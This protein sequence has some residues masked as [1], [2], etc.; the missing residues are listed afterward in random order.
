MDII[1]SINKPKGITSH[2]AV[3]KVKRNL[4][5]KKAGHTG[6]LDP[7]ATGLLLVCVN[8]ATRIASY[9]SNLDKEYRAVMK[10]GEATDT[11]D[12]EGQVIS[13]CD[14][15]DVD[16]ADIREALES[17]EGNILQQPPMFSALKHKGKP[18]YKLARKG[19][20]I[21]RKP[22]EVHIKYI[23]LLDINLPYVT[24]K[25]LCSKGTYIRT[26]CDDIGRKLGTGAHLYE[27]E[28]SGIGQYGIDESLSFNELESIIQGEPINKGIYTMDEALSWLPEFKI[29]DILLKQVVHGNPIKLNNR[30]DFSD[31]LKSAA[32]IRIKSHDGALLAIGSFSAVKN[33]IKMDIVFS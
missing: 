10:L 6:T 5:V 33:M 12:A 13:R 17:F 22:R 24:F 29:K 16:D 26:L 30:T 20:E 15:I 4:K 25:T 28:R 3:S 2:D 31:N 11:Q 23:K 9:F 21:E 8:R 32:G 19:I 1:I 7:M 27:L 14:S 18:L